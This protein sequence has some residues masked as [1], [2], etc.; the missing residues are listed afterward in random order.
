MSYKTL[1]RVKCSCTRWSGADLC[2]CVCLLFLHVIKGQDCSLTHL[3]CDSTQLSFKFVSSCCL[4]VLSFYSFCLSVFFVASLYLLF[5]FFFSFSPCFTFSLFFFVCPS[6]TH[7]SLSVCLLPPLFKNLLCYLL[8]S[9]SLCLFFCLSLSIL[10]SLSVY[11]SV[12][13][14]LSI[15]LFLFLLL[16]TLLFSLSLSLSLLLSLSLCRYFVSCLSVCLSYFLSL[17]T[18]TV[19]W[20][21]SFPLFLLN[22][23]PPTCIFDQLQ[24]VLKFIQHTK[25]LPGDFLRS[26]TAT[27]F[28]L[29]WVH[30]YHRPKSIY[31]LDIFFRPDL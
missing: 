5:F 2:V 6:L 27:E 1:C 14:S 19:S 17:V 9:L 15:L 4:C 24:N 3:G 16:F 20:S 21:P 30:H 23:W 18:L 28:H 25:T 26:S 29:H 13:L 10:L 12:S 31:I 22:F 7:F 8:L 11:S